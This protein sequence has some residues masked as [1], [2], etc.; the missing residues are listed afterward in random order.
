MTRNYSSTATETTLSAPINDTQTS[1][2]VAAT[3]GFPAVPFALTVDT[4]AVGQEVVLVTSVAGTTLTIT[5]GYDSTSAQAHL[6][7]A[8]VTHSHI[9][10]DFRDAATHQG[11]STGVHGATGAVVGTTDTQTLTNKTLGSTNVLNG[12]TASK[13]AV[14][15]ATGKL[16][17]GTS[18][19]PAGTVVGTTDA[20]ALT[21]K[22]LS[23]AT[24]TFPASLATDA[25]VSTA[26]SNHAALTATHGAT[27]AVVGT[28]N[29]QTLTN[30][31]LSTGTKVGAAATDISGAWTA[32]TPTA[33]NFTVG[34]GTLTG[35]YV[36]IGK[37]VCV[38][39]NFTAGSTSSYTASGMAI[40]LP[41]AAQASGM[42]MLLTV[43][44]DNAATQ[45]RIAAGASV[46]NPW[47][48][49]SA[50]SSVSAPMSSATFNPGTTSFLVIEGTYEAA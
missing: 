38:R 9:A 30:K 11:A 31:T 8:V 25:E 17:A 44:N 29:T 34:N 28:T 12:F 36:Q 18:A 47:A 37:T 24:N 19:P 27:G 40:S 1:M 35:K 41:A 46:V 39:I 20:Q 10:M 13:V 48:L 22:D 16:V 33:T 50:G 26:V 21:N 32:Y 42:Q 43:L 4:G 6:A 45:A 2:I 14:T 49:S 3:T 5:R 15:D 23:S 7:G